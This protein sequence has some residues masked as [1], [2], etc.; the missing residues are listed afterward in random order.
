MTPEGE[1]ANLLFHLSGD[2]LEWCRVF[3]KGGKSPTWTDGKELNYIRKK[4]I[5]Q[6]A[7]LEEKGFDVKSLVPL[8]PEMNESY[9]KD[10]E[11]IKAEAEKML[12]C[13]QSDENY[14][15]ILE[16]QNFLGNIQRAFMKYP[17]KDVTAP[18][19][20]LEVAFKTSDY[21]A[22]R[23]YTPDEE[24]VTDYLLKFKLCRNE[25]E[26]EIEDMLPF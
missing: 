1:Y 9:M 3:L 11:E 5:R 21:A 17:I 22:M 18:V 2:L 26:E 12:H 20:K 19:V 25:M 16:H 15:Y 14:K 7:E 24:C 6:I 23:R 10:C 8:P 4:I 13:L